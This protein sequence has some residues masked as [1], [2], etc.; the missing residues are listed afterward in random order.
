MHRL[1]RIGPDKSFLFLQWSWWKIFIHGS[2]VGIYNYCYHDEVASLFHV[3]SGPKHFDQVAVI[4]WKG[5]FEYLWNNGSAEKKD[6][7]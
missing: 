1:S 5:F 3:Q 6:G 7:L 2:S 4:Y